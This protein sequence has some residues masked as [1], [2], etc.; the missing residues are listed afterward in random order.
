[1]ISICKLDQPAGKILG[2][3]GGCLA[4]ESHP[5][6]FN[7][8]DVLIPQCLGY[9]ALVGEKLIERADARIAR[10]RQSRSWSPARIPSRRSRRAAARKKPATRRCPRFCCGIRRGAVDEYEA[11]LIL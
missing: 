2:A 6:L 11:T 5:G 7:L 8:V 3:Q 4:A 10:V 9:G 1:M